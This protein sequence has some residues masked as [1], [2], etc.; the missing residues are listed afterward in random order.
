MTQYRDLIDEVFIEDI[1]LKRNTKTT[2]TLGQIQGVIMAKSY[3]ILGLNPALISPARVRSSIG[4][5]GDATKE[6]VARFV[7]SMMGWDKEGHS[8]DETD[9]IAVAWGG[10]QA[11]GIMPNSGRR[12]IY[13][14][15]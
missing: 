14:F 5:G 10:H 7:K 13:E 4:V 3:Q 8:L 12:P 9:A 15:D 6:E 11:K 1:F 2:I